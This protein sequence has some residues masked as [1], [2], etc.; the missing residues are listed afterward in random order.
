MTSVFSAAG[1]K[2]VQT[3]RIV[4]TYDGTMES[5]SAAALAGIGGLILAY[6]G[7]F[8]LASLR[9]RERRAAGI[10]FLFAA[11]GVLLLWAAWFSPPIRSILFVLVSIAAAGFVILSLL[12]IGRVDGTGEV[13]AERIDERDIMFARARLVPGSPEFSAYYAMRPENRAGDD[14]FRTRPGLLS[15]QAREANPFLFASALAGSDLTEAMRDFGDRLRRV[16]DGLSLLASRQL[17][18]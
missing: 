11:A 4:Q 8:G 13:P 7:C 6:F 10:A 1:R 2:N 18:P 17:Q 5:A 12:P 3:P 9:E 14:Q 16:H 15:P